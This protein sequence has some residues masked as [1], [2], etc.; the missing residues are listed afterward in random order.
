MTFTRIVHYSH[1]NEVFCLQGRLL[2]IICQ[3]E[4]STYY[5]LKY[6]K[7]SPTDFRLQRFLKEPEFLPTICNTWN[8]RLPNFFLDFAVDQGSYVLAC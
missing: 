1:A 8:T 7:S 2:V 3:R 5:T 6:R 4:G